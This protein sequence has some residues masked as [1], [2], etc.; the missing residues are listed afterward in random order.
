[1]PV[2]SSGSPVLCWRDRETVAAALAAWTSRLRETHPDVLHVGHFGS[3]ARGDWGVGSDLDIVIVVTRSDEPP[4]RRPLAF[5]T[6]TGLP[7]PV[8]L[9]VY[10]ADEWDRSPSE[11]PLFVRRLRSEAVWLA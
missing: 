5:D 1:M 4:L 9:V 10:T 2:R 6:I 11:T 8:D 3:H 7:V